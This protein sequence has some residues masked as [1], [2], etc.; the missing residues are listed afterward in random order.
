MV[1]VIIDGH[2]RGGLVGECD[3]GDAADDDDVSGE[4]LLAK[5]P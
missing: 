5:V 2:G 1:V 4:V 3:D